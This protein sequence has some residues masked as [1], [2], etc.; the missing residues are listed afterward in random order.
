MT[1]RHVNAVVGPDGA[2]DLYVSDLPPGQ[3]V[4]ITI[5]TEQ[6]MAP[7]QPAST[8]IHMID[9]IKDLPGH[10]LFKTADDVDAYLREERESWDR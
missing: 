3:Q 10:R 5:E 8:G 2:L 7:V 9:L 6:E 4:T 1:S